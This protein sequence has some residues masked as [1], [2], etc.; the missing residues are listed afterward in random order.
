[1]WKQ[2]ELNTLAPQMQFVSVC[3]SVCVCVCVFIMILWLVRSATLKIRYFEPPYFLE[4]MIELEL[5]FCFLV[6]QTADL[7]YLKRVAHC[8]NQL[9]VIF[10]LSDNINRYFY[11]LQFIVYQALL[12][13]WSHCYP[14][15]YRKTCVFNVFVEAPN[16][17]S[18]FLHPFF[19]RSGL[20]SMNH[21][22][23]LVSP[24]KR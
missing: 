18:T 6:G 19:C 8:F 10:K 3:V 7:Q 1:M 22:N 17:L 11:S 21:M 2:K 4:N 15:L 14:Q 24:G 5:R 16:L 23:K 13:I 9:S 12:H 20:T